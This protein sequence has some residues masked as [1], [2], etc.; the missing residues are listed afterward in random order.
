VCGAQDYDG[1]RM[2]VCD[3]CGVWHHTRCV[4]IEDSVSVPPLFL[5]ILCGGELMGPILKDAL[6]T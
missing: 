3:M 6:V 2:V 4:G 5:C 1:E